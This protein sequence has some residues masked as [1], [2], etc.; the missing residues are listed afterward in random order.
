MKSV[1]KQALLGSAIIH[2]N[3]RSDLEQILLR[4]ATPVYSAETIAAIPYAEESDYPTHQKCLHKSAQSS[5]AT[6]II[7]ACG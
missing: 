7:D 2:S 5:A 4:S 6:V 3:M 1:L